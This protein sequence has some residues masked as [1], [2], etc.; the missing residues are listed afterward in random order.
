MPEM[1]PLTDMMDIDDVTAIVA[2]AEKQQRL[3][4]TDKK[5][6]ARVHILITWP[7]FRK[8]INYRLA[9]RTETG[10]WSFQGSLLWVE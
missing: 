10:F 6:N 4:Q 1:T 5:Y 8:L 2:S 7:G 9:V 3:A